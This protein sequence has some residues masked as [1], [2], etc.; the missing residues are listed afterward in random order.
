MKQMYEKRQGQTPEAKRIKELETELERT[1]ELSNVI[2][3]LRFTQDKLIEQEMIF[4]SEDPSDVVWNFDST[5][6][7]YVWDPS[8]SVD[9][10]LDPTEQTSVILQILK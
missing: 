2:D 5:A 3:R 9:F 8:T 10:E 7:Y 6:G 1:K 4:G